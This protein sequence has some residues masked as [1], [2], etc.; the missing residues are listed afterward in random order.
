MVQKGN[1]TGKGKRRHEVRS[2]GKGTGVDALLLGT[3]GMGIQRADL[4]EEKKR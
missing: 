1:V 4:K 2:K 3:V